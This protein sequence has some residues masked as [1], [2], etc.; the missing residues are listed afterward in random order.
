MT[1]IVE[2][3]KYRKRLLKKKKESLKINFINS[4][5]TNNISKSWKD[6]ADNLNW[7]LPIFVGGS[8]TVVFVENLIY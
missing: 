4:L 5:K 6:W 2:L 8:L 7:M 1:N 3:Y